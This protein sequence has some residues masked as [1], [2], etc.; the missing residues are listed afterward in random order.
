MTPFEKL[1]S[2]PLRETVPSP[3]LPNRRHEAALLCLTC[4]ALAR[5]QKHGCSHS[6][7]KK[8]LVSHILTRVSQHHEKECS[9]DSLVPESLLPG[10]G[11]TRWSSQNFWAF[12]LKPPGFKL[13]FADKTVPVFVQRLKHGF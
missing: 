2:S 9:T 13:F 6:G 4:P 1:H 8:T 10:Q 11:H 7:R 3:Q 12:F 5:E